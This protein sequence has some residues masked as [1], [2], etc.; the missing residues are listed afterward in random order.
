MIWEQ[1]TAMIRKGHRL[2]YQ[3]HLVPLPPLGPVA[4]TQM[5]IA[6]KHRTL[7]LGQYHFD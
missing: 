7:D 1:L 5:T 4:C 6:I 3:S 2:S